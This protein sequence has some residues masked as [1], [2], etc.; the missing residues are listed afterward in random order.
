MMY[1]LSC[2]RS[3]L[4]LLASVP[5]ASVDSSRRQIEIMLRIQYA[6]L[7]TVSANLQFFFYIILTAKWEWVNVLCK[8]AQRS[9]AKIL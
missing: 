2:V 5:S 3:V 8:K 6:L 7:Y 4:N 9:E 1:V